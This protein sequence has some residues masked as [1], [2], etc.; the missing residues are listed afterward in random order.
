[1]NHC[2]LFNTFLVCILF[3]SFWAW[4]E[5]H[6]MSKWR[7]K[8]LFKMTG[9][10]VWKERAL[11]GPEMVAKYTFREV[12]WLF[13]KPMKSTYWAGDLLDSLP[14][15]L[16]IKLITIHCLKI[17]CQLKLFNHQSLYQLV[18]TTILVCPDFQN[19]NLLW[20]NPPWPMFAYCIIYIWSIWSSIN[21]LTKLII[22]KINRNAGCGCRMPC[23]HFNRV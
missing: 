3:P 13:I 10:N 14:C 17:Y 2:S 23:F 21:R 18:I 7:F 5:K 1:M 19:N 11:T 20:H 16:E 12:K 8:P 9:C 4:K 22:Y 15:W 6:L